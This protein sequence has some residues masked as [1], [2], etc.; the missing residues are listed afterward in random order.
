MIQDFLYR[1]NE[2]NSLVAKGKVLMRQIQWIALRFR[3]RNSTEDAKVEILQTYWRRLIG[4][5][6]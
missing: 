1:S 4:K 6:G 2:I 3:T 5:I